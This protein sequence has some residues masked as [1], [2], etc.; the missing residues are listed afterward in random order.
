MKFKH[1]L[2]LAVLMIAGAMSI[3]ALRKSHFTYNDNP[4]ELAKEVPVTKQEEFVAEFSAESEPATDDGAY[5]INFAGKTLQERF[6][7]PEGYKRLAAE[8]NSFA[9]HL[10]Q[11]PLKEHGADVL[12]YDGSSKYNW[13]VYEA[14][15]DLP[16]GSRD[17]HQC[18][19][20][21]MRLR[22]DY[23]WTTK[24]YDK[25]H[26]NFTNGWRCDYSEWRKGKRIV[27]KGN[28]T[29]WR[30]TNQES[31]SYESYWKYMEWIFMFAGTASLSKELEEVQLN[32]MQI[33]DVFILGGHPGHAVIVVDMVEH[34]Q[35][36]KK[37][38]M[39]AQSYMPAQEIQ[40][41][42]NPNTTEFGLW[43]ELDFTTELNT[44]EWTF[45]R[46]QL[47]RFPEN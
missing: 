35:T 11:L 3:Y 7:A 41:L 45:Y 4:E 18:A 31:E 47:M 13:D 22:A 9:G 25:I 10:R 42:K 37:L 20:A 44:P 27:L 1:F 14:V 23:L 39:L 8:A 17:L 34:E 16:I 43:Y 6:P 36:G 15:V 40:I 5:T 30:Q 21:V 46:D 12:H 33:G 2:I 32:K 26:F 28:R 29:S 38:F 19:D 24:Q